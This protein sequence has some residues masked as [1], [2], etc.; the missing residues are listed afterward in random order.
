MNKRNILKEQ[1]SS[2]KK[3]RLEMI[4]SAEHGLKAKLKAQEISDIEYRIVCLEDRLNFE[5]RLLP[6]TITHYTFITIAAIVMIVSII[7]SCKG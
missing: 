1:I 7:R 3:E 4:N 6:F 5:Q 2:L